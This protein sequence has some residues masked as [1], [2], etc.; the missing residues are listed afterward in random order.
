MR[1]NFYSVQQVKEKAVNYNID[2]FGQMNQPQKIEN[3]ARNVLEIDK[4]DVEKF[5]IFTLNTK[6]K[7][8]GIHLISQGDLN[9]SLVHPREVFKRAILNNASRIMLLHNHPS[10]D[11]TPSLSDDKITKRL[12]EA[13]KLL[14][15]NV[16]DHIIIGDNCYSYYQNKKHLL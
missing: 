11:T 7:I 13:G 12:S 8:A 15:I 2:D 1:L 10:G 6:N 5:Y 3:I 9:S 14:G 4:S 16:L